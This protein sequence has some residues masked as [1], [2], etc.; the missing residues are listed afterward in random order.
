MVV[1]VKAKGEPYAFK[2]IVVMLL[3][4]IVGIGCFILCIY[5]MLTSLTDLFL[6]GFEFVSS[7][8]KNN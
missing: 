7:F 6:G 5:L 3:S 8:F 4:S 1:I 2:A